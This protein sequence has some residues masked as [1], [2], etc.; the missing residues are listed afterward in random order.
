MR[1]LQ[2]IARNREYTYTDRP[3]STSGEMVY[4]DLASAGISRCRFGLET[5]GFGH[6]HGA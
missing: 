2:I 1:Q 4:S 5:Y 3:A 6:G